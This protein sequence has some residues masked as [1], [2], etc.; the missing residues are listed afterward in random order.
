[1][2]IE[3]KSKSQRNWTEQFDSAQKHKQN[4]KYKKALQALE[5]ALALARKHSLTEETFLSL[6]ALADVQRLSGHLKQAGRAE[7]EALAM[8]SQLF[9]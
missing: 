1:M 8:S 4:R 7:E 5:E 2:T 6:K 3:T 9:A